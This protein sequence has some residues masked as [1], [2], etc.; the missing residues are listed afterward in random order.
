VN[1][2][3]TE[4]QQ[5]FDTILSENTKTTIIAFINEIVQFDGQ[6]NCEKL[7]IADQEIGGIGGYCLPAN[8]IRNPYPGGLER[9]L[10]R[11][12]QY[13]RSEIE[14]SDVRLHARYVVQMCG[15]HLESVCRLYLKSRKSLG[16]LRFGNITLG[17]AVQQMQAIKEIDFT[18]I[19]GL[20]AYVKVYNC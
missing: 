5:F 10:Y 2:S 7:W 16:A 20:F 4:L 18:I 12:L 6:Y 19:N 3:H 1:I 14:I 17:K 9:E 15:I 11:P 8:P 13:E